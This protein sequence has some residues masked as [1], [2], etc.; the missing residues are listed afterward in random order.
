VK[1][2]TAWFLGFFV[3]LTFYWGAATFGA[4]FDWV[5]EY[6]L[7]RHAVHTDGIVTA[8]EPKNHNAAHYE[9]EESGKR[10][11]SVGQGGGRVGEKVTV[12]YLPDDPSFSRIVRPGDDLTFMVLAPIVLSTLAGF[13][14]MLRSGKKRCRH[15]RLEEKPK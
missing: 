14:V 7:L 1:R 4:G 8:R 2:L 10:Y 13:I 6:R 3:A 12:Y 5:R 15:L 11:R 9:F